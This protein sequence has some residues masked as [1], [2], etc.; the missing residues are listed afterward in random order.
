MRAELGVYQSVVVGTEG[1][2]ASLPAAGDALRRPRDTVPGASTHAA[3][4]QTVAGHGEPAA[5]PRQGVRDHPADL[6]VGDSSVSRDARY[7][8]VD[9]LIVHTT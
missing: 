2:E 3:G 5:A 9:V 1:S 6:P 8:P 7:R 4:A